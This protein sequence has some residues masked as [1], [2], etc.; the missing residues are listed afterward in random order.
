MAHPGLGRPL[1]LLDELADNVADVVRAHDRPIAL[2][3]FALR[4]RVSISAIGSLRGRGDA[5]SFEAAA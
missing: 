3:R 1:P 2:A 5:V 4:I